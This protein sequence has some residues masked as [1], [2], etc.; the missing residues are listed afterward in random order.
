MDRLP[1]QMS[2]EAGEAGLRLATRFA[3]IQ[4]FVV[5]KEGSMDHER[6]DLR[7]AILFPENH[8]KAS[9]QFRHFN[10]LDSP[11][12][13]NTHVIYIFSPDVVVM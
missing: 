10:L 12:V 13:L 2:D 7:K 4:G 6:E 8:W 11:V 3:G 9:F 1:I 5:S